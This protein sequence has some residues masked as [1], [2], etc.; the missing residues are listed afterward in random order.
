MKSL[1]ITEVKQCWAWLVLGWE[2]GVQIAKLSD[3]QIANPSNLSYLYTGVQIAKVTWIGYLYTSVGI[4]TCGVADRSISRQL[5]SSF[6]PSFCSEYSDCTML[7]K[8]IS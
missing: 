1:L 7:H 5:C 6:F 8:Y 3:V 4:F 2:T